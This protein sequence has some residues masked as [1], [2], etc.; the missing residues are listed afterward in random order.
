MDLQEDKLRVAVIDMYN[1]EPGQG[2]RCIREILNQYG[3]FNKISLEFEEFDIRK[4][5]ELPD[6]SFSI[7]ISTG[8]PGDPLHSEGSEWDN[9]YFSLISELEE[10]NN[11]NF[12][13]KKYVFFICHSF[14]LI[15]RYYSIGKI[16]LRKSPSF[17]V[18]PIHKTPA[19]EEEEFFKDIPNPFYA[20]DSRHWQVTEPDHAQLERKGAKIL[21]LEKERPHVPLE[22]ALMAIRFSDYF[23]GTQFHPEADPVGMTVYLEEEEKKKQVIK[24]L[25]EEKYQRMLRQL[26]DPD[27]IMLTQNVV[28]PAFLDQATGRLKEAE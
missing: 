26:H 9:R 7:Y 23:F 1:G 11:S 24:D 21:A 14:Q 18:F 20:V 16:S 25:G 8:G 4:K 28:L 13:E 19:G 5:L 2:M 15:C 10:I 3:E 22:R 12:S 27:K 6:T 17:G